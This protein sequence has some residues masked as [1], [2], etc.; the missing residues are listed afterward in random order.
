MDVKT[1]VTTPDLAPS[2]VRVLLRPL[3][4]IKVRCSSSSS[5]QRNSRSYHFQCK[6]RISFVM[7]LLMLILST[8]AVPHPLKQAKIVRRGIGGDVAYGHQPSKVYLRQY[9]SATPNKQY[10][11]PTPG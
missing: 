2:H 10:L 7:T 5:T 9:P 11:H 4:L 8:V 1:S 6:M 3:L